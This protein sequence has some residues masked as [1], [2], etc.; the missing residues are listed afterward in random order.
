MFASTAKERARSA[1]RQ[2]AAAM[3][4]RAL[5]DLVSVSP[6]MPKA[7]MVCSMMAR[8]ANTGSLELPEETLL[9]YIWSVKSQ[10]LKARP[11]FT[12]KFNKADIPPTLQE[13][14]VLMLFQ[15]L[16]HQADLGV[17]MRIQG[18]GIAKESSGIIILDDNLASVVKVVG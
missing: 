18:T 7:I 15:Q 14:M 10:G 16:E 4:S 6:M 1:F 12:V 11:Q 13:H 8:N 3:T 5:L 2:R 17:A 9:R